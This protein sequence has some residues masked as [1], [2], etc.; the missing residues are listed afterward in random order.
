MTHTQ[1]RKAA[2]SSIAT[3]ADKLSMKPSNPHRFHR[4]RPND[5][6]GH[7][8]PRKANAPG[9]WFLPC[10]DCG[11]SLIAGGAGHASGTATEQSC[12]Y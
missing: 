9:I 5:R 1:S 6:E 3:A 8:A 10:L 2:W 4:G 11:R 7:N 12:Q